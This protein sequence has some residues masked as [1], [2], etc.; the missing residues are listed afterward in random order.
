MLQERLG[1]TRVIRGKS[2]SSMDGSTK[3]KL[4][5]IVAIGGITAALAFAAYMVVKQNENNQ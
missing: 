4:G 2:K 3:G 1:K 5:M